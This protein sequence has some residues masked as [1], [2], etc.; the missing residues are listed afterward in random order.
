CPPVPVPTCPCPLPVPGLQRSYGRHR[1]PQV[2]PQGPQEASGVAPALQAPL[3]ARTRRI[4]RSALLKSAPYNSCCRRA[5]TKGSSSRAGTSGMIPNNSQTAPEA[6]RNP[7]NPKG[8]GPTHR[9]GVPKAG[10]KGNSRF[11][12]GLSPER[13]RI[14]RH[15]LHLRRWVGLWKSREKSHQ[16]NPK[17]Y[18]QKSKKSPK[19]S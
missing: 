4:A 10:R 17:K 11:S 15:H 1:S 2:T 13:L 19:K 12:E 5:G 9:E 14:L 6:P 8:S 18:P 7:G 16:K 3:L